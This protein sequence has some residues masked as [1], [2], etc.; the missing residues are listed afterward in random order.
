MKKI[1]LTKEQQQKIIV[2]VLFIG[3]SVFAYT[4]YFLQPTLKKMKDNQVKIVELSD[5]LTILQR[6]AVQQDR[7]KREIVEAEQKWE[8]L[9][10]KLPEREELPKVLEII[11]QTARRS[12]IE[13]GNLSPEKIRS[14][15]LY[16]EIPFTTSI[17]S[18]YHDLVKFLADLGTMER[19]FHARQLSLTALTGST[20]TPWQTIS[21]QVSLVTFKSKG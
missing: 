13:M 11:T 6:R 2:A 17:R 15:E 9:K 18:S 3:G 16:D 14:Q 1:R 5:R 10:A 20:E 4:K 21:V 8:T 7:L 19:I 12:R